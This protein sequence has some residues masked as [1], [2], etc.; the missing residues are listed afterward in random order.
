[1]E[2]SYI[3]FEKTDMRHPLFAGMFEEGNAKKGKDDGHNR[4]LESPKIRSAFQFLTNPRSRVIITLSSGFPFLFE[5]TVGKGRVLIFCIPADMEWSDLPVKGIFVPLINRSAA[6]VS[7]EPASEH[8]YLAGEDVRIRDRA[9]MSPGLK[10]RKPDG[11]EIL[12]GAKPVSG[13]TFSGTDLPGFYSVIGGNTIYDGFCIN[14]DPA[15]SNTVRSDDERIENMLGRAGI[16]K[17]SVHTIDRRQQ[18]GK[19]ISEARFGSELWKVFLIAA[20][21][22]AI[23]EML[24]ARDTK[25]SSIAGKKEKRKV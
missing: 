15:E 14:T 5:E 1:M 18:A 16:K 17:G 8:S 4:V 11:T 21:L 2:G 9:L 19:T 22:V 12:I 23:T 6:Y 3:E 13:G 20:L 10:V 24:V 7:Q 25:S